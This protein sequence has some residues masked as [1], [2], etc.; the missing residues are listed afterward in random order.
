MYSLVT[1]PYTTGLFHKVIAASGYPVSLESNYTRADARYGETFKSDLHCNLGEEEE[2]AKCLRGKSTEEVM[3]NIPGI[4]R[5]LKKSL[6]F[7]L[8]P[9]NEK[10]NDFPI[11]VLDGDMLPQ[12][13]GVEGDYL[14]KE[15]K[16]LIGDAAHELPPQK[17]T[18]TMKG[19]EA[20]LKPRILSFTT[21]NVYEELMKLYREKRPKD[22]SSPM[23]IT[24]QLIYLAM[25]GDVALSCQ[26]NEILQNITRNSCLSVYRYVI[27]QPLSKNPLGDTFPSY[28][29]HGIDM[30]ALFGIKYRYPQYNINKNDKELISN[31][32]MIVAM[33]VHNMSEFNRRFFNRTVEFWD[34]EIIT[35][36]KLY[37]EKECG[38]LGK[39]GFLKRSWGQLG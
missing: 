31:V 17:E 19:L 38:L 23:Q 37:H 4:K 21:E 34:N 5:P 12:P 2:I 20:F 30:D 3:E 18:Q 24:P 35:W 8:F 33:F 28:A 27:S 22:K 32:R 10:L 13:I 1:S 16:I 15:L 11:R 26:N 6:D 29:Y 9:Y 14:K 25:A 39:Y 7:R 36:D